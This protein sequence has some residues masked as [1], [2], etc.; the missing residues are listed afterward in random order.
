MQE[1]ESI[2]A[3]RCRL[4]ILSLRITASLVMP[5]SYLVTEFSTLQPLKILK[6]LYRGRI[7]IH[8]K[9]MKFQSKSLLT[10]WRRQVEVGFQKHT[11][12][13]YLGLTYVLDPGKCHKILTI[14]GSPQMNF[15]YF[16]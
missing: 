4:K 16:Y 10:F 8:C 6:E 11:F 7:R 5:N 9:I 14:K 3:V 1:K 15:S 12:F 13:F 2:M